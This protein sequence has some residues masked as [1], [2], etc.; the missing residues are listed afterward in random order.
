MIGDAGIELQLPH[1]FTLSATTFLTCTRDY[2]CGADGG[3][4]PLRSR[5]RPTGKS[6]RLYGNLG[7]REMRIKHK[8]L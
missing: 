7:R 2:H 4:N 8:F 3:L 6:E 5:S 1:D